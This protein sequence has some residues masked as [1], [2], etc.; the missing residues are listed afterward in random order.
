MVTRSASQEMGQRAPARAC[1]CAG[2][3][4]RVVLGRGRCGSRAMS[5]SATGSRLGSTASGV[6][7]RP[8]VTTAV[9][10]VGSGSTQSGLTMKVT[11]PT[12]P[13]TGDALK[14]RFAEAPSVSVQVPPLG[15]TWRRAGARAQRVQAGGGDL[16]NR[17][18]LR[19]SCAARRRS[20]QLSPEPVATA[21]IAASDVRGGRRWWG[22]WVRW[23]DRWVRWWG[24]WVRWS[25][26]SVRWWGR[27][28]RWSG[29]SVRWSGRCGP[30]VGVGAVRWWA[31]GPVVGRWWARSVRWS[32]RP[33]GR[34]WVGRARG[35]GPRRGPGR[36]PACGSAGRSIRRVVGG[37][38]VGP[39]ADGPV[40]GLVAGAV[41]GPSL[42]RRSGRRWARRSGPSGQCGPVSGTARCGGTR[43]VQVRR[44]RCRR[45][46][47]SSSPEPSDPSGPRP[48][49]RRRRSSGDP[50]IRGRETPGRAASAVISAVVSGRSAGR[51]PSR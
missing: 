10:L 41:A 8:T 37:P 18:A 32:G 43:I 47:P 7:E 36:G 51:L 49:R 50:R 9:L 24:R 35:V 34:S 29:R 19:A 23:W 25:G 31:V 14:V 15:V 17:R 13:S 46:S 11:E 39:A 30:V 21:V 40:G 2:C 26:R 6:A 28:V 1:S 33:L 3:R 27:W 5:P 44:C 22:R 16:E 12:A 45:A 38:S 48:G 4:E 42:G 20:A